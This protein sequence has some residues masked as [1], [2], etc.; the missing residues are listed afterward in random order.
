MPMDFITM[1][2]IGPFGTTSN[3]NRYDLTVICM[4]TNSVF[5]IPITDK[6]ADAVVNACLKEIY[7]QFW[8]SCKLSDNGSGFKNKLFV[9]VA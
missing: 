3:R 9:E 8:G 1:D 4:L 6:T 2:L 5:C 7:C